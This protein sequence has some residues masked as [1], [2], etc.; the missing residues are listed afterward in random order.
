[1]FQQFS[2]LNVPIGVGLDWAVTGVGKGQVLYQCMVK[3]SLVAEGLFGPVK[4]YFPATDYKC[5]L[6]QSSVKYH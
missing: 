6:R 3:D 2:P 4:T 1:M 5:K